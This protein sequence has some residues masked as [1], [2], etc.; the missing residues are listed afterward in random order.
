M[1]KYRN[2][3]LILLLIV[4]FCS[5][6]Y[7]CSTI[8]NMDNNDQIITGFYNWTW[9]STDP[10]NSGSGNPTEKHNIGILFGGEQADVAIQTHMN[11]ANKLT[12]CDKKYLNL[13][14]GNDK[15]AWN[16]EILNN[17]SND[18]DNL[19]KNGWNGLCYDLEVCKAGINCDNFIEALKNNFAACKKSGLDVFV[20]T[21]INGPY[22]SSCDSCRDEILSAILDDE[23]VTYVSPQLY[24]ASGTTL[25]ELTATSLDKFKPL[26]KKVLLSIPKV[27]KN[28]K[29]CPDQDDWTTV[30][31]LFPWVGGYI[32][33]IHDSSDS[34][35]P[36][37]DPTNWC[38]KDW[39]DAQNC[40]KACPSGKD[41]ECDNGMSCIAGVAKCAK[42]SG[43]PTNWCGKDWTDA[44]K[45]HQACPGGK[46]SE[47]PSGMTC[48]KGVAACAKPIPDPSKTDSYCGITY[49]DASNCK[50]PCPNGVDSDCS[51]YPG[52]KCF[53]IDSCNNTK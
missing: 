27:F 38:G 20:T 42:P 13:G 29:D 14:G 18:F 2:I 43:D 36:S 40:H 6:F 47:C 9:N 30:S 45:C 5:L 39:T 10:C 28:N 21:N 46:D 31:N 26:G 34:P 11:N 48:M 51:K 53:K 25:P 16:S 3:L 23:N 8:E 1:K 12:N 19:K 37:G 35:S 32:L 4:I 7:K 33:W 49:L 52:M 41:S 50:I 24:G 22:D 15:G 17:I 44:Q